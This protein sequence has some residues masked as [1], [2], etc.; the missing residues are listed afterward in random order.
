M[1]ASSILCRQFHVLHTEDS[2]F[3]RVGNT[4]NFP[5]VGCHD[6]LDDRQAK[7]RPLWLGRNVR[8][9]DLLAT[10][11]GY[12]RPVV[13]NL[14]ECLGRVFFSGHDLDGAADVHRLNGVEQEVEQGLAKQLFVRF[15]GK[16]LPLDFEMNL[17]LLDIIAKGT[18]HFVDR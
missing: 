11:R 7:S 8:L 9:E 13:A 14:E 6:L 12:A 18:D 16:L 3:R 5:S 15:D 1:A 4:F 2:T 17:F 10:V